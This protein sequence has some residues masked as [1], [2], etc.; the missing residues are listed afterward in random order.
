MGYHS[1]RTTKGLPRCMPEG[2][3]I[4]Q[5]NGI[6]ASNTFDAYLYR[7]AG[8][9]LRWW[10]GGMVPASRGESL[11]ASAT[12]SIICQALLCLLPRPCAG[13]GF[14]HGPLRLSVAPTTMAIF[15]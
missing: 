5:C 11:P 4:V 2:N 1:R 10:L 3:T 15:I 12:P 8:P 13:L 14:L 9:G 7:C 6:I